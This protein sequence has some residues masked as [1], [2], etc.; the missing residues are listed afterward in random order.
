ME[1]P[2]LTDGKEIVETR[3]TMGGEERAAGSS[4]QRLLIICLRMRVW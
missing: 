1:H 4:L 2:E 3:K